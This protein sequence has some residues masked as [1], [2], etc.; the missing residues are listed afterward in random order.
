MPRPVFVPAS[1]Q[2]DWRT[3]NSAPT[4]SDNSGSTVV[5]PGGITRSAVVD[6]VLSM[7]GKGTW[8]QV[9]LKYPTAA[10]VTANTPIVQLFG[11]DRGSGNS[12]TAL[13]QRLLDASSG[14][15]QTLSVD[16]T[17][18]VRDGTYSYTAPVDIDAS[19]CA[20]VLCAIKTVLGGSGL[21]GAVIQARIK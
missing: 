8:V 20:T 3:I 13:Y 18:D 12:G 5:N 2:T 21:T 4:T 6:N 11:A 15:E 17:N 7:S 14:H 9:R 10:T 1:P 19:A 16:T